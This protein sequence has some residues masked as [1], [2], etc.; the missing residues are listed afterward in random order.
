MER[1]RAREEE[2]TR[3]CDSCLTDRCHS[4]REEE[5]KGRKQVGWRSSDDA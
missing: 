2:G 3:V 5:G 4:A 1:R